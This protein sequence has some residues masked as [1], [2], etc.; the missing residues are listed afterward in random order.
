[1]NNTNLIIIGAGG[2]G[3][4]CLDIALKVDIWKHIYFLDDSIKGSVLGYPV[5]SRS[6][7]EDEFW[8]KATYFVAIGDN[9]TRK[10]VLENLVENKLN[11]A[12]LIHPQAVVGREVTVSIG[13]VVMAGV[14]I[15]S[16]SR[17]GRGCIINTSSTVDHDC[18]IE[19]YVH[20]SPGVN[21]AGKVTVGENSWVGMGSQVVN[22][23]EIDPNTFIKA[24]SLVF[25]GSK[26]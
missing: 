17:I 1:M 21:L 5:V 22:N 6:D 3:K 15:N 11:I 20:L 14:V 26:K 4:V 13:S 8:E 18:I 2:Q 10:N 7:Y 12:T 25:D 23:T 9:S 16:N 24:M 19:D